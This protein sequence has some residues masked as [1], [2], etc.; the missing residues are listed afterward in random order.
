MDAANPAYVLRN[1][2]AQVAIEQAEAGEFGELDRLRV[3][4]ASPYT[5]QA[6]AEGYTAPPPSWAS[7][8][9]VCMN[10]CSS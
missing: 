3:L 1:Y 2:M 5:E 8:R 10:S 7:R 6:G 9:G 4:L